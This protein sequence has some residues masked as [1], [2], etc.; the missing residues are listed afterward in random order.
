[1][2]ENLKNLFNQSY[3]TPIALIV[4]AVLFAYLSNSSKVPQNNPHASHHQA[5]PSSHSQPKA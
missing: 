3:L 4:G 5:K 2:L 1:M